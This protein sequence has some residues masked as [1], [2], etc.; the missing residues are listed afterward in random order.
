REPRPPEQRR[1]RHHHG[2]GPRGGP[3]EIEDLE[4]VGEEGS[5]LVAFAHAGG[6]ERVGG[7]VDAAPQ[8]GK[9]E[10]LPLEDD[11]GLLPRIPRVAL[12]GHPDIPRPSLRSGN[13]PLRRTGPRLARLRARPRAWFP[14][15]SLASAARGSSLP[16]VGRLLALRAIVSPRLKGITFR[17]PRRR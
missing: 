4:A 5:D 12:G 16:S 10:A 9:R 14:P 17:R 3:V 13:L 11:R 7:P 1:E 6:G 2:T 15:L 8:P